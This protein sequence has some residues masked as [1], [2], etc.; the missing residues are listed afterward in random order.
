MRLVLLRDSKIKDTE[1]K[2]L[3]DSFTEIYKTN[4]GIVPEF[5]IETTDFTTYPFYLDEDGDGRLAESYVKEKVGGIYKRYGD[6]GTDHVVFLIH[7]DNWKLTGLWGSNFSGKY[8]NYQVQVCRFDHRN[9]ANAL[10]TLYHEVHHSHDAF[11]YMMLGV[12]LE[13]YIKVKDWDNITHGLEKPWDYIRWKENQ[14][15][16]KIVAPVLKKAY[17]KRKELY[18]TNVSLMQQVINLAQ[19][20]IVLQRALINKK[21]I[22][23][24]TQKQ[25]Q[26]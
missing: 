9:S 8:Y 6:V 3:T 11:V 15:A 20:V 13:D 25:S 17:A 1:L 22:T 19:Q 12:N 5:F 14:E 18:N 2:T 26:L 21:S 16:L 4:T 7:R 24:H 10:G 23:C